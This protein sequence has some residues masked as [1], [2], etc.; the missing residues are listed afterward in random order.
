[1][2]L[3]QLVTLCEFPF[4]VKYNRG[5]VHGASFSKGKEGNDRT[6]FLC[7]EDLTD[8]AVN[9]AT[10]VRAHDWMFPG[11][12]HWKTPEISTDGAGHATSH[13]EELRSQLRDIIQTLDSALFNNTIARL[14][15]EFP[16]GPR[17]GDRI[18][19]NE[20]SG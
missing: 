8:P 3:T 5:I 7:Y 15:E 6:L 4:V 12:S 19:S 9:K 20:G 10:A 13:N 2:V 18:S 17:Y 1:M 16:C 11:E 14:D